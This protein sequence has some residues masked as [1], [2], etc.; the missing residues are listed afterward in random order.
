MLP[1]GST[2]SV[3]KVSPKKKTQE[4]SPSAPKLFDVAKPGKTPAGATSRP[5][6]V[7]HGSTM[8]QDPMFNSPADEKKA[9]EDP[10]AQPR[11][12]IVVNPPDH[13]GDEEKNKA[14]E[15]TDTGEAQNPEASDAA[16]VDTLASAANAKKE[17]QKESDE[18]AARAVELE[19]I[20]ESKQYFV[21]IGEA[22]RRRSN[23][24]I[25]L[26]IILM[27]II[28]IASVNFGIDAEVLDLGI[29]PLT[30]IL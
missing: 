13:A 18:A 11:K 14:D 23:Q 24:R 25:L 16:A 30:D 2:G 10:P 12:K 3:R 28:T 9:G 29:E 7:G 27:I 19:K 5:V 22:K 4:E 6:I 20:I 26:T 17:N 15:S 21:P 8:K 1:I